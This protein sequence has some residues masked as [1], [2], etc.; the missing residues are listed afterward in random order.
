MPTPDQLGSLGQTRARRWL[1][2]AFV[3]ALTG[4]GAGDVTGAAT[5]SSPAA[6]SSSTA[7]D[8]TSSA[9]RS[10]T[11]TTTTSSATRTTATS[12]QP[13]A[14]STSSPATTPDP[15]ASAERSSFPQCPH[16]AQVQTLVGEPVSLVTST[17]TVETTSG[18]RF[19]LLVCSYKPLDDSGSGPPR[20]HWTYSSLGGDDTANLPTLIPEADATTIGTR[21]ASSLTDGATSRWVATGDTSQCITS[22]PRPEF[23]GVTVDAVFTT[24]PAGTP[25]GDCDVS[26]G[27]FTLPWG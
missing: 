16:G 2:C 24:T 20:F 9:P 19:N 7:G 22:V 3:V 12:S 5:A 13:T 17:Q 25:E 6:P 11:G 21:D 14:A 15:A 26:E 8:P 4:C 10:T 23:P 1:G 27:F 18:D